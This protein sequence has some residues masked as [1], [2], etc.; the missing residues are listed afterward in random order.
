MKK[1]TMS[2]AI[3]VLGVI[4]LASKAWALMI[5]GV[6]NPNLSLPASPYDPGE[7][8]FVLNQQTA[9][10]AVRQFGGLAALKAALENFVLTAAQKA[11]FEKFVGEKTPVDALA[12]V[13]QTQIEYIEKRV[14]ALGLD[15][16]G[17]EDEPLP[18][19]DITQVKTNIS[20]LI[21]SLPQLRT[22]IENF[23]GLKPNSLNANQLA[24]KFIE[25]IVASTD[26]D[27]NKN[28][29]KQELEEAGYAFTGVAAQWAR[30]FNDAF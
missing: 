29:L 20:Q 7:I 2:R 16:P 18:E 8:Q 24:E 11:N 26:K 9:A 25:E 27:Y 30:R 12:G 15:K 19:Q 13:L 5:P 17:K 23:L 28:L 10:L 21:R 4:L 1:G 14:A 3:I 22:D 6:E